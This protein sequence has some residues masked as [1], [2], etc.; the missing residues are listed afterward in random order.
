MQ[1]WSRAA[2]SAG[3]PRLLTATGMQPRV[4]DTSEGP[5]LYRISNIEFLLLI[6]RLFPLWAFLLILI[7][8]QAKTL[9]FFPP[10]TQH[11]E[12]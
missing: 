5:Q 9:P 6:C 2:C 1:G 10:T 7:N 8:A 12:V 11:Q 4:T 3:K